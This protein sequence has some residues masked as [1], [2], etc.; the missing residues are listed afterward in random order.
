MF[1]FKETLN[2]SMELVYLLLKATLKAFECSLNALFCWE[3]GRWQKNTYKSR[4]KSRNCTFGMLS[5][6]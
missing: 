5:R 1:K 3:G 6:I 4:Q 2:Q